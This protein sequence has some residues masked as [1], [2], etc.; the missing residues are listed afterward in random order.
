MGPAR[1]FSSLDWYYPSPTTSEFYVVVN[2]L[3]GVNMRRHIERLWDGYGSVARCYLLRRAT[4]GRGSSSSMA[5]TSRIT[6]HEDNEFIAAWEFEVS[7]L[8]VGEV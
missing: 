4:W 8:S 6:P 2:R 5:S 3:S 7:S 1:G